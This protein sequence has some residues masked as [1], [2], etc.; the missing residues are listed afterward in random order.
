MVLPSPLEEQ[1]TKAGDYASPAMKLLQKL[2]KEQQQELEDI[3][4]KHAR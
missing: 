2:K 3:H 1:D 4:K